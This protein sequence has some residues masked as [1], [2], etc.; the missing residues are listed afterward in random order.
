MLINLT[1]FNKRFKDNEEHIRIKLGDCVDLP[2]AISILLS[3]D[4]ENITG[5]CITDDSGLILFKLDL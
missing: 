4:Y 5:S 3:F 1:R 2:Q